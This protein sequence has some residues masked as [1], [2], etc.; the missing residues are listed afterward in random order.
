VR[1]EIC[2]TD[3]DPFNAAAVRNARAALLGALARHISCFEMAGEPEPW[4]TTIG[5]GPE[6]LPVRITAQ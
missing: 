4:M 6:K 3:E 2:I 5:H 1:R